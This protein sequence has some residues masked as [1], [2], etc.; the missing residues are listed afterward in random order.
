MSFIEQSGEVIGVQLCTKKR[1]AVHLNL[2]QK[3]ISRAIDIYPLPEVRGCRFM[4]PFSAAVAG[5][6]TVGWHQTYEVGFDKSAKSRTLKLEVLRGNG[7]YKREKQ[8]R[9]QP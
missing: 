5:V 7:T 3:G 4:K 8:A 9:G 6:S 2:G 1:V